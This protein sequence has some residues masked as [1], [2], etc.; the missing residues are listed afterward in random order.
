MTAPFSFSKFV[1]LATAVTWT[2]GWILV[3]DRVLK[4][5]SQPGAGDTVLSVVITSVAVAF[6]SVMIYRVYPRYSIPSTKKTYPKESWSRLITGWLATIV[7]CGVGLIWNL[8]IFRVLLDSA[9][10]GRNANFVILI[11]FALV[12]L[13]LLL[14]VFTCAAVVLDSIFHLEDE[15]SAET[16]RKE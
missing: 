14:M 2:S 6:G 12:G 9:D 15:A 11:P 8:A 5:L 3:A 1:G 16:Q 13:L 7:W 4:H 10:K